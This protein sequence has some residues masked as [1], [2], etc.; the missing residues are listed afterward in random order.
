MNNILKKI[1]GDKKEWKKME[2]R[3]KAL[4]SDYQVVYNEI[5][6]Y[7]WNLWRFSAGNDLG[8]F[9]V[10]DDLLG[11]FEEGAAN[12]K[13]VLDVT[14]EDVAGFCDDLFHA[15][16]SWRKK[17]NSDIMKKLGKGK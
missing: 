3:A 11:L 8:N 7:M 1:I 4:P 9:A 6:Q 2:A 15:T 16:E 14:G 10:L 17:L 5:K 13:S 12:G